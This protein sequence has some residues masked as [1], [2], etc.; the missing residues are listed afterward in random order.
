MR[1]RNR[2][3]SR[4]NTPLIADRQAS[5]T[6]R[7]AAAR[8]LSA[9]LATLTQL[10][11]RLEQQAEKEV[12]SIDQQGEL[13]ALRQSVENALP[14]ADLN[15]AYQRIAELENMARNGATS[16]GSK[17]DLDIQQR[18]LDITAALEQLSNAGR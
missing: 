10:D 2:S 11:Q 13:N 9:E 4:S 15:A 8:A 14:G 16:A 5:A 12:L 18:I 3:E 7:A 1:Q 17:G 6:E